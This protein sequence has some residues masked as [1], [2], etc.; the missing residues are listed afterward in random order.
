MYGG[1]L[2]LH[3]TVNIGVR[4]LKPMYISNVNHKGANKYL[5]PIGNFGLPVVN[6]KKSRRSGS[7]SSLIVWSKFLTLLL[8]MLKPW[9]ALI[10]S[11]RAAMTLADLS[12]KGRIG[13]T[14]FLKTN[15]LQFY[16]IT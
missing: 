8:S 15:P 7:V 1:S 10:E 11:M 6:C 16:Q 13:T 4:L 12:K 5:P 3:T 9:S 14:D 2:G